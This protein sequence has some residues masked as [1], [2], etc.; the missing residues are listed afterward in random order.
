MRQTIDLGPLGTRSWRSYALFRAGGTA[1]ARG[2]YTSAEQL[3][4]RSLAVDPHHSA[5]R[6]NLAAVMLDAQDESTEQAGWASTRFDAAR[7]RFAVE[8]LKSVA[9]AA[10]TGT[11]ERYSA[12]YYSALYRLAAASYDLGNLAEAKSYSSLLIAAIAAAKAVSRSADRVG[13]EVRRHGLLA[14][15]GRWFGRAPA[16]S[17]GNERDA[18]TRLMKYLVQIEPSAL[19][20]DLGLR[21][22][23][24]E[25]DLATLRTS[26]DGTSPSSQVQYN[27]ACALSIYMQRC[28]G[29]EREKLANEAIERL[30]LAIRMR[31]ALRARARRDRS[32]RSVR[33]DPRFEALVAHTSDR[34]G[35]PS[36]TRDAAGTVR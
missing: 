24:G 36:N 5:A 16:P 23:S 28:D 22:E 18:T 15:V 13:T 8:Q 31:S 21:L 34:S 10:E 2:D 33:D 14:M 12:V 29:P 30:H 19:A 25:A 20:M 1:A 11:D 6:V 27:Y 35:A 3:Y 9:R 4:L 7:M 17:G 32:L 26:V